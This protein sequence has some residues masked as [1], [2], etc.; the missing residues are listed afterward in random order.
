M[1]DFYIIYIPCSHQVVSNYIRAEIPI[2]FSSQPS[3]LFKFP[4]SFLGSLRFVGRLYSIFY[5]LWALLYILFLRNRRT[6]A[7]FVKLDKAWTL[8]LFNFFGITTVLDVN[9]PLCNDSLL[10]E[11]CALSLYSRAKGIV[12]E[13]L[14]YRDYLRAKHPALFTRFSSTVIEDSV[15]IVPD[16]IRPFSMREKIVVWYGNACHSDILLDYLPHLSY[17]A[18]RGYLLHLLGF[19][20]PT[21]LS[22]LSG[23]FDDRIVISA[24]T[25]QSLE[26]SLSVARFSFVPMPSSN[27]LYTLRGNLKCKIAISRGCVP[28]AE[29]VPMHWRL[30]GTPNP[31]TFSTAI[32][33]LKII[34][35][36]ENSRLDNLIS[37]FTLAIN[38]QYSPRHLTVQL[39]AFFRSLS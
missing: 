38:S 27:I 29:G 28:L 36:F 18:Q 8:D 35:Y 15:Q 31:F 19:E 12:F 26:S 13:S 25:T 32:D 33:V 21:C 34:S 24:L 7:Y 17:L 14:E 10:G 9:D 11:K 5:Y 2:S 3:C 6:I 20:S 16:Y 22:I 23:L 39:E 30:F 1:R 4:F 37:D